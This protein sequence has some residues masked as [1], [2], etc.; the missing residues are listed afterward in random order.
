MVGNVSFATETANEQKEEYRFKL[1]YV[2]R[3]MRVQRLPPKLQQRVVDYFMC[4]LLLCIIHSQKLRFAQQSLTPLTL[5]RATQI[6]G[7]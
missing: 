6:R 4:T 5:S 2:G 1:N 7:R 3:F